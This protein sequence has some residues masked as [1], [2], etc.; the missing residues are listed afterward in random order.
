[1]IVSTV[2][3]DLWQL[4]E[5]KIGSFNILLSALDIFKNYV[6]HVLRKYIRNGYDR[7]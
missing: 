6:R 4:F 1:M 5:H 3:K 7:V 2:Q